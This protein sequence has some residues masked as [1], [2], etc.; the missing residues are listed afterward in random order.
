MDR[1]V[2]RAS[3]LFARGIFLAANSL[4]TLRGRR[5]VGSSASLSLSLH[6]EVLLE[7]LRS[8]ER[9]AMGMGSGG[10]TRPGKKIGVWGMVVVGF[11]WVHGGEHPPRPRNA[12]PRQ[13]LA[14]LHGAAP[15]ML[16]CASRR[17]RRSCHRHRHTATAQAFTAT[18]RC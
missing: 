1:A 2:D 7:L 14:W 18:R 17:R 9:G 10:G 13:R 11:F 12:C 8:R 15:S 5:C 16:L 6:L 3:P 4:W